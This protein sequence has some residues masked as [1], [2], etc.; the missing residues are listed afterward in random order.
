MEKL[1]T[2]FRNNNQNIVR[3]NLVLHFNVP[4][5]WQHSKYKQ[6]KKNADPQVSWAQ[7]TFH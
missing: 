1:M 3:N 2:E 4:L 7:V 6:K 5:S